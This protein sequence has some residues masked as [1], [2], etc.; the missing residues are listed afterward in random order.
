[1]EFL[2]DGNERV[3]KAAA[4]ALQKIKKEM[5]QGSGTSK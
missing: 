4:E 1:M 5:K 3:R 2:T